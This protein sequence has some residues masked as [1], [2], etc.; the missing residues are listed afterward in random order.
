MRD[1]S[2]RT[3]ETWPRRGSA[4]YVSSVQPE[5]SCE[6][7]IRTPALRPTQPIPRRELVTLLAYVETG[8]YKATA[9][10]LGIAQST[11]RQRVSK[12]LRRLKV[13]NVT[14]AVWTLRRDL[15]NEK[16]I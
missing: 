3:D 10:R 4:R 16:R 1:A 7:A 12:L 6:P 8:S 2:D 9:R 14:Q 11:A 15:E 13:R 5:P